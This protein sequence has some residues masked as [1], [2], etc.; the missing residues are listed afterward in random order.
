VHRKLKRVLTKCKNNN[1][2][3]KPNRER[4]RKERHKKQLKRKR[5]K[6][7]RGRR[8]LKGLYRSYKET[9]LIIE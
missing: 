7:E 1:I 3:G 4:E 6:R 9:L 2:G 5:G 8:H